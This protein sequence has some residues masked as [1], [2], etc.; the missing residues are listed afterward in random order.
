MSYR[1]KFILVETTLASGALR[2]GASSGSG[3]DEGCTNFLV[4]TT[5]SDAPWFKIQQDA[6]DVATSTWVSDILA[7]TTPVVTLLYQRTSPLDTTIVAFKLV[8]IENHLTTCGLVCVQLEVTGAGGDY[9]AF[10]FVLPGAYN[11]THSG[12]PSIDAGIFF[13]VYLG[14]ESNAAFVPPAG[15]DYSG[16]N[17][18]KIQMYIDG[19][20]QVLRG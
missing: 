11:S 2:F 18:L 9:G 6:F 7:K 19:P 10:G 15:D 1:N 14:D 16:L 4:D 20:G 12:I 8:V 5:D 17:D 13:S 3:P